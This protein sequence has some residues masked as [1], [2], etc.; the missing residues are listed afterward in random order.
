MDNRSICA[1]AWNSLAVRPNGDVMPCCRFD[2]YSNQR[3]DWGSL[4]ANLDF[5]NNDLWRDLRR[6][7]LAGERVAECRSCYEAEDFGQNSMRTTNLDRLPNTLTEDC[8]D[9]TYLEMSFS[10]LCNLACVSCS[11]YCSSKWGT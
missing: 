8:V 11:V 7:M 10:N 5:R 1:F 9:L 2:I 6:K 3:N 4:N